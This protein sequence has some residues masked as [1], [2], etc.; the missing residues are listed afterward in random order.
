MLP[1]TR[2]GA[3]RL[4]EFRV[5]GP[6]EVVRDGQTVPIS[7]AMRRAALAVLLVQFGQPTPANRLIEAL[8]DDAPPRTAEGTLHTHL[9]HLRRLL[10]PEREA[11]TR[12]LV[13]VTNPSGYMIDPET[14]TLDAR[15]FEKAVEMGRSRLGAGRHAEASSLLSHALSMWRG[16][17]FGEFAER[18]FARHEATRLE[19]VRLAALEDRVEADLGQGLHHELIEELH[20]LVEQ[21]P[22]RERLWGHLMTALYRDGR[23]ADALRAFQ[24]IR[25]MLGREMGIEPGPALKQLEERI[26]LQDPTLDVDRGFRPGRPIEGARLPSFMTSFVG[27]QDELVS[28]RGAIAS[29]RLVTLTGVGGVGKSRLAAEALRLS[30]VASVV[31]H[32]DLAGLEDPGFVVD[33]IADTVGVRGEVGRTLEESLENRLG[34]EDALL[35]LDNADAHRA[36][37]A[38]VLRVLLAR[39]PGLR[40]VVT[41][42][43]P[44]GIPG[45]CVV[46]ASPMETPTAAD[47]TAESVRECDSVQLFLAR[48]AS[49]SPRFVA[50][51]A[52]VVS[53]GELCNRLGGIPLGIELAA[54]RLRVLSL[55]Q[56]LEHVDELLADPGT[57][58]DRGSLRGLLSWSYDMLTE[59]EQTTFRRLGVFSG[60]FTLEMARRV[61]E[62]TGTPLIAQ[63]ASLVDLALVTTTPGRTVHYTML[64]L[65]RSH[66][67]SM[68]EESGESE[69]VHLRHAEYFAER[70][71]AIDESF[72]RAGWLDGLVELDLDL[73]VAPDTSNFRRA[74]SWALDRARP[75]L[76]LTL[77]GGLGRYW[78][79]RGRYEEAARWMGAAL[80]LDDGPPRWRAKVLREYAGIHRLRG[81]LADAR[82][83]AERALE[84]FEEIDDHAGRADA[85]YDLGFGA[86]LQGEYQRADDL[87]WECV[88]LWE[89][90]GV[91]H[92]A[93]FPL[94]L[95]A[96]D[97]KVAGDYPLAE[98]LWD[99]IVCDADSIAT[100]S[101]IQFWRA[102]LAADEDDLARAQRLAQEALEKS[103]SKGLDRYAAGARAVLARL[104]LY[105]GDH[106]TAS[107]LIEQAEID[108]R[109]AGAIEVQGLVAL[110]S[111]RV[112][113]ACGDLTR[114]QSIL[115]STAT[116]GF[117]LEGPF[118]RVVLTELSAEL[119]HARGETTEAIRS[120]AAASVLRE[121]HGLRL[122]IP[123]RRA[124]DALLE[125]LQ[126]LH[127]DFPTVWEESVRSEREAG[128]GDSSVD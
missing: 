13:L 94:V 110:M 40:A 123:E 27:R 79:W 9:S 93:V 107:A 31:Q 122:P 119:A 117:T 91:H 7:G 30:E 96:W 113:L 65:A 77:A 61:V 43:R 124:R 125:E 127:G 85:L 62:S 22:L 63:V 89:R 106:D 105:A 126:S 5:L 24:E 16:A 42:R 128:L 8:W 26:L 102:D 121:R 6:V 87:L 101:G 116:L 81:S 50:D 69:M 83:M 58:G 11:R 120:L 21:N 111:C 25:G 88:S 98:Q 68:L 71:R 112:A 95:L 75:D 15:E 108:A 100:Q 44:I 35:F 3:G 29:S 49:S 47:R 53:V 48:S 60:S 38:T 115:D 97:A 66:A 37:L 118:P 78:K 86:L 82:R 2:Q 36:E 70:A 34:S 109:E 67:R 46:P 45:E 56:L 84:L 14:G 92:M 73:D 74:L 51:A 28:V 17:A 59:S 57:D 52:T 32:I 80:D 104:A 114:A 20:T 54:S 18:E 76:A 72:G 1:G 23:Q 10:D 12:G 33:A 90:N 64:D 19:Q 55:D 41:C 4:L 39:C 99:R 103:T